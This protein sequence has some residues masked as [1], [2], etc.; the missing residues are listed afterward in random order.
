MI[1]SQKRR[2]QYHPG[3]IKS[4]NTVPAAGIA[5][6]CFNTTLVRLKGSQVQQPF[7]SQLCFNTT[8][9]RLKGRTSSPKK[10]CIISFNTTLVRLKARVLAIIPGQPHLNSSSSTIFLNVAKMSIKTGVF[11]SDGVEFNWNFAKRGSDCA[12]SHQFHGSFFKITRSTRG[13][14][15]VASPAGYPGDHSVCRHIRS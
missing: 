13:S 12:H 7:H 2:F 5:S 6:P 14:N 8:L 3:A 9:V 15:E 1:Q 10:P 4:G 11:L